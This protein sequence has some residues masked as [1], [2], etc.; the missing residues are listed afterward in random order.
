[1]NKITVTLQDNNKSECNLQIPDSTVWFDNEKLE[2]KYSLDLS[3]PY[4]RAVFIEIT[5][6]LVERIQYKLK[7]CKITP[8]PVNEPRNN[9]DLNLI[10]KVEET[11]NISNSTNQILPNVTTINT[12][13][14][15]IETA[16]VLFQ[17]FDFDNSGYLDE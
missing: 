12:I 11:K 6:L 3:Q 14:S 16:K 8:D 10:L 15:D 1:M 13:A 7:S 4:E 2:K 9:Q 17:K 5:F